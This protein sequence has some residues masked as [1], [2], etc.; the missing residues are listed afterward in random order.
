MANLCIIPARGGSKRIPRKNIKEFLGR[1]IIAYSI[2]AAKNSQL[3]DTIMVSTDD[4]EIA[5]IA[6]RFGA[7]VPFFRSAGTA[8]DHATT[9]EALLE[10]IQNFRQKGEEF[11]H[12]CCLYATAPLVHS[13]DLRRGYETLLKG[14]DSVFPVVAFGFPIWRALR[15]SEDGRIAMV[16]PEYMQSRSQDL[17]PVYHDAGQWYWLKSSTFVDTRRLYATNAQAIILDEHRVQ[18]IDNA[19]DWS[20]AE[21]KY[22]LLYSENPDRF[23]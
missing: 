5:E 2:Q 10:V 1:P 9:S 15:F 14:Y 22:K 20:L 12:V 19:V 16:W 23:L 7:E 3:F 18:D 6:R 13:E 17:E 8:G 21:M 11:D 4:E